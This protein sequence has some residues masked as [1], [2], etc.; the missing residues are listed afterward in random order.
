MAAVNDMK[1]SRSIDISAGF[2]QAESLQR[3][4]FVEPPKDLKE[5]GFLWKL[6]KPLYGLND[7]G[8]RFWITCEK[9]SERE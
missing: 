7:A 8:R 1:C 2:R 5:D 4:V 3:D 6:N 9:N